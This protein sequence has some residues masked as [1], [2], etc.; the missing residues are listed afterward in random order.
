MFLFEHNNLKN[1]II[2]SRIYRMTSVYNF[3]FDNIS[4]I[5]DDSCGIT[6]KEMQNSTKDEHETEI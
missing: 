3:T 5:G 1:K 4:R 2:L 6:E